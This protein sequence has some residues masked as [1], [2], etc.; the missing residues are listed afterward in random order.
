V[1]LTGIALTIAS[2]GKTFTPTVGELT[3]L[4]KTEITAGGQKRSG[5]TLKALFENVSAGASGTVTIEGTRPDGKRSAL[6]RYP[7]SDVGENT[8]LVLDGQG[9]VSLY[10]TRI[11]E[12][13]WLSAIVSV[14][15]N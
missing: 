11:P 4:P 15:L 6:I 10:S 7:L 12:A 3:L 14:V 5:P 1:P 9:H 8:V 13:E 2:G